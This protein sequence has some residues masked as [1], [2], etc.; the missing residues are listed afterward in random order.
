VSHPP[1]ETTK[2]HGERKIQIFLIDDEAGVLRALSLMLSA[3]G[4]KVIAFENPKEAI[5]ALS[6][7]PQPDCIVSDLRMPGVDGFGVLAARNELC[8]NVPFILISGHATEEE[9]QYA[10]THGALGT[11]RKP[12]A[13]DELTKL[14]EQA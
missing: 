7:S 3:F 14:I 11:L 8:P 13:P 12:F 9:L 1:D 10:R 2:E 5:Q 4:Y 6:T